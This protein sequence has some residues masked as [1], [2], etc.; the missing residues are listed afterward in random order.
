MQNRREKLERFGIVHPDADGRA[1]VARH[2]PCIECGYDVFNASATG[3]CPE[4]GTAIAISLDAVLRGWRASDRLV[5]GAIFCSAGSA[6]CVAGAIASSLSAAPI[7]AAA[8]LVGGI[9]LFVVGWFAAAHYTATAPPYILRTPG[10]SRIAA[11]ARTLT[12]IGVSG[13]ILVLVG[14]AAVF[15][16]QAVN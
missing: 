1:V 3:N 11:I 2:Y 7:E 16:A 13:A 12:I 6:L 10:G 5:F 14:L 15:V 8:L 4:C 9:W